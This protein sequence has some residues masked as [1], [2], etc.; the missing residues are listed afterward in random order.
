M[1]E[2]PIRGL[3]A[4]EA[5]NQGLWEHSNYGENSIRWFQSP[6]LGQLQIVTKI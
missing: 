5:L 3:G 1:N 6:S 2:L 4:G